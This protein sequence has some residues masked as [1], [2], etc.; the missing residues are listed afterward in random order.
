MRTVLAFAALLYLA[1]PTLAK[2]GEGED[3]NG[4]DDEA[5]SLSSSA[6]ISHSSTTSNPSPSPSGPSFQFLQPGNTTTCQNMM[7]HWQSTNVNVPITIAV[8]NDRATTSP[9]VN[10]N[11]LISRT[12]STN[13]SPSASQFMWAEVDVP[14]GIYVAV[15]F[16]TSHTA[17]F[18]SQS[19]PFFVQ[20]GQNSSCLSAAA[21]SSSTPSAP[22][23]TSRSSSVP[24]PTAT[25]GV[26][27]VSDT[28]Q[29]KMLSPAVLGGV[30]AG[31]IVGVILLILVFTF[32]HYWKEIRFKRARAR[33]PGGPYYLF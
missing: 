20:T 13:I 7:F 11:V 17:G 4:S 5:E 14:Q 22:S 8:T 10:D 21:S 28:A 6:S 1:G 19:P 9:G 24:S 2:H 16:D 30:V 27:S 12:L 32:P 25:S 15:A 18:F 3:G 23:H 29:P 26:S 33:R 31:V